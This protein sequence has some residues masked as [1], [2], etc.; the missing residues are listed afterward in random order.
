MY[1][2]WVSRSPLAGVDANL[3]V[4]VD[5]LLGEE[6]VG[7]AARRVGVSESAMSHALARARDLLGDPLLVRTG[8][9]MTQTDRARKIAPALRE[10]VAL[11]ASVA[12]PARALDP[13]GEQRTVRIAATDFGHLIIGP[14]L[15]AVVA[16]DAP[17]VDL[18]FLP[19]STSSL[20][21]L[22]TGEIDLAVSKLGTRRGLRSQLLLEEPF[23]CVVRRGHPITR[24]RITAA[25][26]AALGHV[27]IS[28]GGRVRGAVD[29]ALAERGL[30]RRV[31]YVS[32]TFLVAAQI[33][34]ETDLVMTCSERNARMATE[35]LPLSSFSPPVKVAPFAQGMLW[36]E[37][38]EHDAFLA[39]LRGV[40][41][42]VAR[43]SAD[44]R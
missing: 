15:L 10:A 26:F 1:R 4:A 40:V 14:P 37:R 35:W 27:L 9:R 28:P 17:A 12:A 24:G 33:V 7:A 2:A 13:R 21:Q 42:D 3:L 16:R 30:K 44:R 19:F 29:R 39:W 31:V 22:A 23:V 25:R 20:G 36:H 41:A 11:L 38:Q 8:R 43:S 6:S 5:A 32:P 18:V 34:A